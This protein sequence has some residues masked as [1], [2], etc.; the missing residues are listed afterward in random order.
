LIID[1]DKYNLKYLIFDGFG[2]ENLVHGFSS[3]HG[4]VSKGVLSSL[5]LSYSRGDSE[6]NV[7]ENYR[8]LAEALDLDYNS[9]VGC[10]QIHGNDIRMI[11]RE[12]IVAVDKPKCD[13][14]ITREPGI[15]LVTIHADCTP[16]FLYDD[17]T[18]AIGMVHSGWKGTLGEISAKAVAKMQTCFG[19]DP[20]NIKVHIGPSICR[21]CFEVQDDVKECFEG[22]LPWTADYI[23]RK[24]TQH[25][26]IDLKGIINQSL[27]NQG[28]Q[29][30]N[31]TDS[32][33]C[34][35]ERKDLFY[36]HRGEKGRTGT[37]AALIS[38]RKDGV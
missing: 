24:D 5:N 37:M 11:T 25:W 18:P 12:D 15:V 34:T 19:S 28:I 3:R 17:K 7:K 23:R 6:E 21:D 35:M 22:G 4:G 2:D 32:K 31:I 1:Y 27:I 33:D 14:L 20:M 13:G 16:V 8:R 36:S 26:F 30:C 38:L 29:A 10:H 9:F